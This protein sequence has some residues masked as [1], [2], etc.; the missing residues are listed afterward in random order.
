MGIFGK[1]KKKS[2]NVQDGNGNAEKDTAPIVP[3]ADIPQS[4][5]M[6]IL[7]SDPESNMPTVS[8]S[9]DSSS[10]SRPSNSDDAN[11]NDVTAD[12]RV[13]DWVH[14]LNYLELIIPPKPR[15]VRSEEDEDPSEERSTKGGEATSSE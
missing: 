15:Q 4:K 5:E 14:H 2:Q 3:N 7:D 13:Q 8:P 9:L 1:K 12:N 11:E 10:S 6:G